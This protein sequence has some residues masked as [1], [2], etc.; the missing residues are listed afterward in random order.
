[1]RWSGTGGTSVMPTVTEL[2]TPDARVRMF[3][4][5]PE[6]DCFAVVTRRHVVVVDTFGTPGEAAQIMTLLGDDLAG[7]SLLV[8]NTHSH[9]DHAWGNSLFAPGGPHPAPILGSRLTGERL[10]SPAAQEKLARKQEGDARF[11]GVVL[12]PPTVTFGGSLTV[13]GG[14]LTL[15]LRPAPGH[16]ADQLVVWIPELRF[17]LAADALEFPF[18]Y[19]EEAADLP[20]LQDTMRG[21]RALHPEVVLPCHG[22]PHDASLIE[23][24][25]AYFARLAA[26]PATTFEEALADLGLTTVPNAEFYRELHGLNVRA[27]RAAHR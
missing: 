4:S 8:V 23:K 19:A 3:R 12:H 7:R 20:V 1:M 17:L 13:D 16:A 25:L 11:A 10:R 9:Y 14:D 18:P 24:N 26:D 2:P 5:D 27:T 15:E 21:L 22:G 6:V